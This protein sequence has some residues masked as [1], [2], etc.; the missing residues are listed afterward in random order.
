MKKLVSGVALA[1]FIAVVSGCAGTPVTLGSKISGEIPVGEER[2]IKAEGCG[3]QLL[4]LIPIGV[5]DRMSRAYDLLEA[6]AAGDFITDVSV[7]ESWTYGFVGTNY[8]SKL[9]AKAIRKK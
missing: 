7:E 3:F 5:N 6:K 8:C 1:A 4:L 9:E 2:A